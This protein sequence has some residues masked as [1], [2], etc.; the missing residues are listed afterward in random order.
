MPVGT[1]AEPLRIL[2]VSTA[3]RAG[4]A[5]LVARTL[6]EAYRRL[7]HQSWLAV[8]RKVSDDPDVLV[9]PN[10][11][12]HGE[13]SRLCQRVDR[14]LAPLDERVRAVWRVR[15]LA[16]KFGERG[17]EL[18][19]AAGRED[20]RYPASHRVLELAPESPEVV[21]C[22]NLHGGYFD[23]AALPRLSRRAPLFLTMHDAWLLSGHCA[24]SFECERWRTG[25][26]ECPDLTIYPSLE[27]DGTVENWRRKQA[28]YR[29]SRLYLAT[30]CRWLMDRV[31]A[32]ILAAGIV[33]SR[34][35]PYGIDLDTFCP[36][37]KPAVRSQ[38]G[39]PQD[40]RVL[41]FAANGI[42]Q[43]IWKDYRTMRSAVHEVGHRAG[44][45]P[46]LFL[47]LGDSAPPE[48]VGQAEIR[49]IPHQ[50]SAADVARYYQAA[51]I[52]LHAARADTFPNAVLEALGCGLPVVGTAV[53]GIP[54]QVRGLRQGGFPAEVGN[55]HAEDRATGF[56]IPL[57]D[58]G[59]MAQA[60]AR[61]VDDEAL[62]A[63]LGRNAAMDARLRFRAERQVQDY[64][65]WYEE[66]AARRRSGREH[67]T[68]EAR[69][70]V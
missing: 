26:G 34:I 30:P 50:S 15:H 58:A 32:S 55:I 56:L 41:L 44:G 39:I 66:V 19:R 64:L 53:G 8:G 16:R 61:L 28:I 48:Q 5:E 4:G 36:G 62:R 43:N 47:A 33:E 25:C 40:A 60:L 13:W 3:D 37:E 65:G 6:F 24:H 31:H 23:L 10:P 12:P 17:N 54:E 59:T 63:Q 7:G 68:A 67:G 18:D 1:G 45:P 20:F 2:T 49:F 22:H 46:V 69:P 42:R 14:S 27:V 9:I 35:I 70:H 11:G 38:L 51:D 52:Y 57:G 21:H 29:Q